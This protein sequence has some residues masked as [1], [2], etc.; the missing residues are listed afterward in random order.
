MSLMASFCAVLFPLDV[1]DEIWDFIESVSEGVPTYFALLKILSIK[2]TRL[3]LIRLW[4]KVVYD[5]EKLYV[6]KL[7]ARKPHNL[8]LFNNSHF[9]IDPKRFL[10]D[11]FIVFFSIFNNMV[12]DSNKTRGLQFR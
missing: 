6:D 9:Y 7:D 4:G 5:V 11:F 10:P 2:S 1:F 12:F 3:S 8:S